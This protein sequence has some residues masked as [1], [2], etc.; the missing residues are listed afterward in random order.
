MAPRI[1]ISLAEQRLYL[2]AGDQVVADYP[3]ST[4]RNGPGE[5]NCC[6]FTPR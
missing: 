6:V 1:R 3:V 4:A 5:I 2:L